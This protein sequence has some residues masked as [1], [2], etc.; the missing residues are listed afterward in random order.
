MLILYQPDGIMGCHITKAL[1]Y[2]LLNSLFNVMF[3]DTHL[4]QMILNLT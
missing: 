3:D 1:I 4:Y 2:L